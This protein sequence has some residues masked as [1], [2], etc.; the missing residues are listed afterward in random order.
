MAE[1]GIHRQSTPPARPSRQH[2]TAAVSAADWFNRNLA[3]SGLLTPKPDYGDGVEK[4]TADLRQR[5]MNCR[6]IADAVG[7]HW[8]RVVQIVR[9]WCAN[10]LAHVRNRMTSWRREQRLY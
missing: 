4:Q 6:Q 3:R 2:C 1:A 7:L 9:E 5:G 8:T 10:W